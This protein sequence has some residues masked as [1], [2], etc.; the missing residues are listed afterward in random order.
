MFGKGPA[1]LPIRVKCDVEF[2]NALL[3]RAGRRRLPTIGANYATASGRYSSMPLDWGTLV[4]LWFFIHGH[5]S[6]PKL[7]VVTPS[8]EIPLAENPVRRPDRRRGGTIE[9]AGHVCRER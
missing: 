9:K 5:S 7:V 2:A 1:R 4:P 3:K 6:R 8:R